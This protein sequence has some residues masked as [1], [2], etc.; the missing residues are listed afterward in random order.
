MRKAIITLT[1]TGLMVALGGSVFASMNGTYDQIR[2]RDQLKLKDGSCLTVAQGMNGICDRTN[3]QVQLKL[4][5]HDGSCL[6]G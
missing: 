5:L 4:H 2:T 3:D 1:L 6:I